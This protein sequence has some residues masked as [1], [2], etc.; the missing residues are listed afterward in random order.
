MKQLIRKMAAAAT[1]VVVGVAGAGAAAD[2]AAPAADRKPNT[3]VALRPMVADALGDLRV[4]VRPFNGAKAYH[5]RGTVAVNFEISGTGK[6]GDR[7]KHTGGIA[8]RKGHDRITLRRFWI[9]L[10]RNRLSGLVDGQVRA[11]LFRLIVPSKRPKLGDVRLRLTRPAA[12]AINQTFGVHAF[13]GGDT[14]GFAT[15]R[16]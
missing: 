11:D 14:F 3:Q 8:L 13:S 12:N 10:D 1:T 4:H 6:G 2:A 15:V 7:I 16:S 9:D 5:F